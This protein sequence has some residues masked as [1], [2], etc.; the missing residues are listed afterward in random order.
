MEK[1]DIFIG[2]RAKRA[3]HSKSQFNEKRDT[4]IHIHR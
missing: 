4:Y 2:E 1:G 3:R